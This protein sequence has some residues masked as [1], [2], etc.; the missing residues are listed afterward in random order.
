[1]DPALLQWRGTPPTLGG[2]SLWTTVQEEFFGDFH[3]DKLPELV[4]QG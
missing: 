3:A 1:M 2:A 4:A